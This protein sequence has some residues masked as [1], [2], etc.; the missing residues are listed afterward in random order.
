ML[1]C[2][3]RPHFHRCVVTVLTSVSIGLGYASI[4]YGWGVLVEPLNQDHEGWSRANLDLAF[5]FADM[6]GCLMAP[7]VGILM[8]TLG[9]SAVIIGSLLAIASGFALLSFASQLW[10]VYA[11]FVLAGFGLPGI[12]PLGMVKMIAN[13][14]TNSPGG[15]SLGMVTGLVSAGIN[16]GGLTVTSLGTWV[17]DGWGFKWQNLSCMIAACLLIVATFD[18]F[19]LRDQPDTNFLQNYTPETEATRGTGCNVEPRSFQYKQEVFC[20]YLF[21]PTCIGLMCAFWT[22]AGVLSQLNPALQ[23]EGF[24]KAAA[25]NVVSA[26]AVLAIFSKIAT[27]WLS[28]KITAR[29]TLVLVM[30]GEA[31]ALTLFSFGGNFG[32]GSHKII[33]VWILMYGCSFGGVGPLLSVTGIET[34]GKAHYGKV[35]GLVYFTCLIPGLVGPWLAGKSH[36]MTGNYRNAFTVAAAM[37]VVGA[38]MLLISRARPRPPQ[39]DSDDD[40]KIRERPDVESGDEESSL[41]LGDETD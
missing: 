6:S 15:L 37:F 8:D 14:W 17:I 24:T 5:S 25:A 33:A 2:K 31:F 19:F 32:L 20:N 27:G 35:M 3:E 9:P 11:A 40:S 7:I 26:A 18:C 12:F 34:F 29:M 4:Y 30:L 22:Y 39:E 1:M 38:F 13:W 28:G 41:E 21:Y 23:D 36:D 16:I 10:Q